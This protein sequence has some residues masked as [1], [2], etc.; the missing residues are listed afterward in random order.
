MKLSENFLGHFSTV[1]DPRKE[2]RNKRHKLGDILVLALLGVICGADDW[3][4]VEE[5]GE[6]K[7]DWL[8]TFL[9]LPNGIPSH[10]TIGDVFSRISIREFESSFLSWVNAC[11]TSSGGDIIPIDGKTL[12]RSHHRK[13]GHAA[14][15][16]ISAWSTRNQMVLGQ[17]K[18]DDKSNEITA[19]PELLKML[20]I[21]G[22]TVTIDAMGCQRKIAE[23]IHQQGGDY[24]LAV[25]ENQGRL[26]QTV[27]KLFEATKEENATAMWYREHQTIDGDH[28]RIERRNYV[29]LPLMYLHGFKYKWKGLQSIAMVE[30]HREAEGKISNE[31]RYYIASLKPDAK[32][33]GH[34]I[35]THWCIENQLHWSMDISFREDDSRVRKGDAAG[36]FSI[37]R[38]IALNLLKKETTSKIGVKNKRKKAGWSQN[39]LARV[40]KNA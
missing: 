36:N 2:T 26:Y 1:K 7:K 5:F 33:I 31:K 6:E 14:I 29:V 16:M 15:H 10:D 20:D 18:V 3:V 17:R 4:S 19:I 27:E 28:G 37:L 21:T 32:V 13:R 35:R 22:S 12:R 9:E 40:L 38:Q 25:K 34:A 23:Q 8:K 24:V 11:V 30:S 39:Y